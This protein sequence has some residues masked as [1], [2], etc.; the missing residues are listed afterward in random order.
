MPFISPFF[1]SQVVPLPSLEEVTRH[2]ALPSIVFP[3]DHIALIADLK[4]M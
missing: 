3:S 1:D 4:W 2:C